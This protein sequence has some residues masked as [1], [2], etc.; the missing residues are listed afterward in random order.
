MIM[1]AMQILKIYETGNNKSCHLLFFY[2][3]KFSKTYFK[4]L[5][6]EIRQNQGI[7]FKCAFSAYFLFTNKEGKFKQD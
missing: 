6:N 4:H 7:C 1:I 5:K 3:F 2:F